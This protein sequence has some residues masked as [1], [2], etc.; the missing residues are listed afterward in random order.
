VKV[1]TSRAPAAFAVAAA[2]FVVV[3]TVIDVA[4]TGSLDPV[5]TVAWVPAVLVGALYRPAPRR[6]CSDRLRRRAQS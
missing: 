3:A 5:W 4:R 2:V 1:M 6:D